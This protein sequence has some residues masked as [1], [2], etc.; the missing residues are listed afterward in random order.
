[1]NS[2]LPN[3]LFCQNYDKA[4]EDIL[5]ISSQFIGAKTFFIGEIQ[6]GS[7]TILKV[8]NRGGIDISNGLVLPLSEA[9]KSFFPIEEK[10]VLVRN[11]EENPYQI[12]SYISVPVYRQNGAFFG[13]LCAADVDPYP[14][15]EEDSALLNRLAHFLS[16]AIDCRTKVIIDPLTGIPN[17]NFLEH[18]TTHWELP[19]E[20]LCLMYL[21][22][23]RFKLINDTLGHLMGDKLLTS[24][25]KRLKENLQKDDYIIR[26]GGDEF[27]LILPSISKTEEAEAYAGQMIDLF[28]QPF[29]ISDY[30][31][32]LTLSI[33]IS[34]SPQDGTDLRSLMKNSDIAMYRA[35]E[36]GRNN[37]QLFS[38]QM[39]LTDLEQLI[40]KNSLHKAIKNDEFMLLYQP[41]IHLQTGEIIGAEALIR[42]NHP[43]LG[44]IPPMKF[45]PLAEETGLILP[46]GEWV[47]KTA[48]RQ[49]K[50]WQKKGYPPIRVSVNLSPRQFTQKNLVQM[51]AGILQETKLDP[52]YLELE[53][54]E[55]ISIEDM[56]TVISILH[57]LKSL[58][59]KIAID[60]FGTGHSSLSYLKRFPIHCL[61]ID[62]SFI[63]NIS[64]K[65][66]DLAI[67]KAIITMAHGLDL[68]IVAEGIETI[69]Q[70]SILKL[71]QCD[72][73]QG[74]YFSKPISVD[75]MEIRFKKD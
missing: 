48:C 23:D 17:R 6:E 39:K 63:R 47:L 36:K 7:F 16:M 59:V 31:I 68:N 27:L 49:N 70:L 14:F 5:T 11:H 53:I 75:E 3:D 15:S 19:Q 71:Y 4:V 12:S 38:F 22:I 65:R 42:W 13:V 46:I 30:E 54:T 52:E 18:I 24:I 8:K 37:Y 40:L 29:W 35:K 33:G 32:F 67:T 60:D 57:D 41:R 73:A 1:M 58:G 56:E 69:E 43:D 64:A 74:Y 72:E 28:T 2:L 26:I 44:L 10:P 25:V 20:G 9:A 51:L 34:L 50:A 62:Q 66:G 21:D 61:K 45:I 55:S